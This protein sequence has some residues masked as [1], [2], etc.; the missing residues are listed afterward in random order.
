MKWNETREE[1]KNEKKNEKKKKKVI[2]ISGVTLFLSYPWSRSSIFF[3]TSPSSENSTYHP[4]QK[5][6]SL[7]L[8]LLSLLSLHDIIDI[9]STGINSIEL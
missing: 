6:F 1:K 3:S 9:L 8:S 4:I 7:S 5:D 2:E